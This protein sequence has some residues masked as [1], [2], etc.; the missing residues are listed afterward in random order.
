MPS[1][2]ENKNLFLIRLNTRPGS[3]RLG[4]SRSDHL[5]GQA[6][7]PCRHAKV[8]PCLR[9]ADAAEIPSA[10]PLRRPPGAGAPDLGGVA[11]AAQAATRCRASASASGRP[12]V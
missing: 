5:L 12:C 2:E 7:G 9:Q 3:T 6:C 11:L 1:P 10:H 4:F 8:I